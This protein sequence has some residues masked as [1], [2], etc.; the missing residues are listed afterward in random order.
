MSSGVRV[1]SGSGKAKAAGKAGDEGVA[2][3]GTVDAGDE[4]IK[5]NFEG[6]YFT[7]KEE[8]G[9]FLFT[10]VPFMYVEEVEEMEEVSE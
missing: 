2:I 1:F 4:G 9:V 5:T 6:L 3:E 7:A 10:E 8:S